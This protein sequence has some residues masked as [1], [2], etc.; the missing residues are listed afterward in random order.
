MRLNQI[1]RKLDLS[2]ETIVQYLKQQGITI[3]GTPNTKITP[4]QLDL[5]IQGLPGGKKLSPKKE[6]KPKEP[7]K[8]QPQ[9]HQDKPQ[10]KVV[11][12]APSEPALE[13][14][15][16]IA[17]TKIS[18]VTPSMTLTKLNMVKVYEKKEPRKR[19]PKTT[20][21]KR[22]KTIPE[23]KIAK[24]IPQRRKVTHAEAAKL[25]TQYRQRKKIQQS[26]KQAQSLEVIRVTNFANTQELALLMGVPLQE[27]TKMCK[28]LGL[29]I[30]PNQRLDPHVI[31][32]IAESLGKNIEIITL[33]KKEA[34]PVQDGQKRVPRPP[35]VV[36]MGHVD[37]GKTSLL[38]Y[39]RQT[40]LVE[41]ETGSIT[42][43]IGAYQIKTNQDKLITFLDTPG[44]QAF[45]AMRARGT[46]VADIAIIVI[47]ADDGIMPQTK[48]AISHAQTAGLPMIFAFSKI[49]KSAANTD[50]VKQDL[51]AIQILVEDWGG[52]FQ[53]QG[54]SSKTGEGIDVL[55]EKVL[56][57]TDLA[58]L[59]ANPAQPASGTVI[60]ASLEQGRGHVVTT[61]IEEGTLR[62]GN[63]VVAGPFWGKVKTLFTTQ[64]QSIKEALPGM[65]VQILGI[66]GA[67]Q[68]GEPFSVVASEQEARSLSENL[69]KAVHRQKMLTQSIHQKQRLQKEFL[70]GKAKTLKLVLK[71]DKDGSVEALADTLSSLKTEDVSLHIIHKAVGAVSESDLLLAENAHAYIIGFHT[72]ILPKV[73]KQLKEKK[74]PI[75]VFKV[76]YDAVNYIEEVLA[77]KQAPQAEEVFL[78]RANVVKIFTIA[79]VGTVAGCIVEK[80]TIK[81]NAQI[82]I[83]RKEQIVYQGPMQQLK[84]EKQIIKEAKVGT[85]CGISVLDFNDIQ[86]GD[87][88]ECFI[89]N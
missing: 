3:Q 83:L 49:D 11:P 23:K 50:K 45:T 16:T 34:Q 48:E 60:E 69:Y 33:G 88:I 19:I 54:I 21:P 79:R 8:E 82:R 1:A 72:T 74:V 61:I 37:H 53:S 24:F 47:A 31:S 85:E 86:E 4:E 77:K 30:S 41:K 81:R 59:T 55:L 26:S 9:A 5:L 2:T 40:K 29:Q 63:V 66:N 52:K 7:S 20:L 39:L 46:K 67:P 71:A 56:L 64:T 65:P 76:I 58:G 18:R 43:H 12:A 57:E 25:R 10:E 15:P 42:Q 68:A 38:D 14:Q 70:E 32:L 89:T 78:G 73:R 35:I 36:V 6:D 28:E 27:V 80:G 22:K 51:A 84:R 75:K 62:K 87:I 44:H 17:P 13:Q